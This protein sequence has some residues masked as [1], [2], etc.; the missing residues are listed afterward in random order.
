M[1]IQISI[2]IPVLRTLWWGNIVYY[3][4]WLPFGYKITNDTFASRPLFSDIDW[5]IIRAGEKKVLLVKPNLLNRWTEIGLCNENDF[6]EISFGAEKIFALI[7]MKSYDLSPVKDSQDCWDFSDALAFANAIKN[8]RLINRNI[9]LKDAIYSE[10]HKKLLPTFTLSEDI[11]DG[12]VLG[13]WLSNGV[14]ISVTSFRRLCSL[15]TWLEADAI[16]EIIRAAGIDNHKNEENKENGTGTVLTK[17]QETETV[18]KNV[19]DPH[20]I[21][22]KMRPIGYFSLPGRPLL[23]QFFNEHIIDVVNNLEKY[24]RM[25]LD[26]PTPVILYGQPGSGKTYA[27]E[28]LATFM[29][30]PVFYVDSSTIASPYIHDTSKKIADVFEK[31]KINAPS[32]VIIDEMEAYLSSRM[33]GGSSEKHHLEE[34]AEFLRVVQNASKNKI[35]LFGMTNMIDTLDPAIIRQGR[36]DHKLEVS[37]P[38]ENEVIS[39]LDVAFKKLPMSDNIE[40]DQ[41]AKKLINRPFSDAAFVIREAGRIAVKN[42]KNYIDHE[43]IEQALVSLPVKKRT[44]NSKKIGFI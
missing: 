37:L 34:V 11:D 9:S 40:I 12:V 25:G 33:S 26:F 43:C 41:I 28:K 31:A 5:Q 13:R 22:N 39:F 29:D 8:T 14:D 18:D 3:E 7:T 42:D 38:T 4:P 20:M 1:A 27:V 16:R 30:W 2:S 35:L 6:L 23:E 19:E 10:E 44:D 15:V 17:Q 24:Q 21:S 32:I 36:F